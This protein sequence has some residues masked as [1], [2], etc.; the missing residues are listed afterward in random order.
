MRK[1]I[2][3]MMVLC[4]FGFSLADDVAWD[5]GGDGSAW[6]DGL[7]WDNDAGPAS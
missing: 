5:A 6:T 1:V 3:L 7:N 2:V 4:L